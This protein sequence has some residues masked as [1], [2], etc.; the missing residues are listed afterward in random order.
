LGTAPWGYQDHPDNRLYDEQRHYHAVSYPD[1]AGAP[2]PSLN[3]Q[4]YRAGV[5]DVRYLQAL[6]RALLAAEKRMPDPP[7]GLADAVAKGRAV[8]AARFEAIGGRLHEYIGFAPELL[9]TSRREMAEAT[10]EIGKRLTK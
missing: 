4:A 9:D 2:I 1:E 3:W 10:V 8:H 7:A 6:R 5:D